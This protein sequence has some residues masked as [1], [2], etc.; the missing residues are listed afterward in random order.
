MFYDTDDEYERVKSNLEQARPGPRGWCPECARERKDPPAAQG[1]QKRGREEAVAKQR[2]RRRAR[3]LTGRPLEAH[4]GPCEAQG[5]GAEGGPRERLAQLPWCGS[6]LYRCA[7][8]EA[9]TAK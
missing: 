9:R 6:G 7:T 5:G 8:G 2:E 4:I 1:S 3:A